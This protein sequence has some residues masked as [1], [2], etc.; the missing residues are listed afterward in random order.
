MTLRAASQSPKGAEESL[1]SQLCLPRF[2]FN[3]TLEK[4]EVPGAAGAD[5]LSLAP[6]HVVLTV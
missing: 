6:D 3:K 2:I 1:S 5:G 4:A